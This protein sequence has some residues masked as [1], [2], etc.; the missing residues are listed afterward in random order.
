[1]GRPEVFGTRL[2]NDDAKHHL[3]QIGASVFGKS[4]AAVCHPRNTLT[5]SAERHGRDLICCERLGIQ[6]SAAHTIVDDNA[7]RALSR[8]PVLT[9]YGVKMDDLISFHPSGSRSGMEI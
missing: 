8:Q 4:V 6:F 3:M 9:G 2:I 5:S 1:M 7:C